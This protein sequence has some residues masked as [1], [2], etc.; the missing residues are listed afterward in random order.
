MYLLMENVYN[1]HAYSIQICVSR[2]VQNIHSTTTIKDLLLDTSISRLLATSTNQIHCSWTTE[3][4]G[5]IG[6]T[7][8]E[9]FRIFLPFR[10][11]VKSILVI[12][13][14][15]KL[16]FWVLTIWIWIQIFGELLTF[17]I[18]IFPKNKNSKHSKLSK[19]QFLTF[20]NQPNL[21]SR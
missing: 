2:N 20:W 16:P 15:Q 18:Q 7:Q 1:R 10:L 6:N 19:R 21:I 12:L 17:S 9:N 14:P 13:K 11:Y 4:G 3:V 5:L 8:C